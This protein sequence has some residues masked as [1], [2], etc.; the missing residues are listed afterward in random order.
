MKLKKQN[1]NNN[2]LEK[3]III[4]DLNRYGKKCW[5]GK[6]NSVRYHAGK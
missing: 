4:Q 2:K 3:N 6:L 1:N 5:L